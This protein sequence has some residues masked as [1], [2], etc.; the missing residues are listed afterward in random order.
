[1]VGVGGMP[2]S[3][4][5]NLPYLLPPMTDSAR[6]AQYFLVVTDSISEHIRDKEKKRK[7]RMSSHSNSCLP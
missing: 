6:G 2:R 7:V 3:L 4:K 5:N 1:M